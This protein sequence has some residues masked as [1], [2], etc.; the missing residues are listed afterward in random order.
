MPVD[1]SYLPFALTTVGICLPTY[2][3]I[4]VFNY[5]DKVRTFLANISL[6]FVSLTS[7]PAPKRSRRLKEKIRER[8]AAPRHPDDK[9]PT[10]QKA[11]TFAS[12]EARLSQDL[13]NDTSLRGSQGFIAA[14]TRRMSQSLSNHLPGAA[15]RRASLAA[16]QV[17]PVLPTYSEEMNQMSRH[18]HRSSTVKFEEPLY[19]PTKWRT[20]DSELEEESQNGGAT[21]W[22]TASDGRG[23]DDNMSSS[24]PHLSLSQS[25]SNHD[26]G[27]DDSN[28]S[29]TE[30]PSTAAATTLDANGVPTAPS[31]A[32]LRVESRRERSV[33]P[34]DVGGRRSFSMFGVGRGRLGS[35]FSGMQPSPRA[36]DTDSQSPPEPV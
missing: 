16:V 29:P 6:F 25:R 12:L 23:R 4:L 34:N 8:K 28:L 36:S 5:P 13:S 9:R 7:V 17:S 14:T 2:L 3:L 27:H 21:R 30:R 18:R 35:R 22:R 1:D 32:F 31:R 33:S 24:R 10:L 26:H 15:A 20:A 11:A 19:S